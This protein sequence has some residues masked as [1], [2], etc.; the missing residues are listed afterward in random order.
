MVY[1]PLFIFLSCFNVAKG[2]KWWLIMRKWYW[3]LSEELPFITRRLEK[4]HKITVV[5]VDTKFQA[6]SVSTLHLIIINHFGNIQFHLTI[7]AYRSAYRSYSA[8]IQT[9]H[10]SILNKYYQQ[11]YNAC[12]CLFHACLEIAFY[13]RS[14]LLP[15]FHRWSLCI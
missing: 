15:Y 1:K 14:F 5:I 4:V 10:P 9:L 6:T 3:P 13:R 11:I 12:T 7:K 2:F 8:Q